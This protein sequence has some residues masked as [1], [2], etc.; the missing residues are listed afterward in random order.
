MV[1]THLGNEAQTLDLPPL[2]PLVKK[3]NIRFSPDALG[4]LEGVR[5]ICVYTVAQA[6]ERDLG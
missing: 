6:W 4:E 5:K 2:V 3:G 1:Y